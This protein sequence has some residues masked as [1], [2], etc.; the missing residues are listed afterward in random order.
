MEDVTDSAQT[1]SD[2]AVPLA[3]QW[4]QEA[5]AVPPT[6][7]NT[8][9]PPRLDSWPLSAP[10]ETPSGPPTIQE[11]IEGNLYKYSEGR[12]KGW[13]QR[14]FALEGGA[15]RWFE[16]RD[17]RSLFNELD[18]DASGF[19]DRDEVS[20]LFK[21]LGIKMKGKKLDYV[22]SVMDPLQT[23][24]VQFDDFNTWWMEFGGKAVE[25]RSAVGEIWMSAS[26][27]QIDWDEGGDP[28]VFVLR[29]AGAKKKTYRLKADSE[30]EA[31]SWYNKL[32]ETGLDE[33]HV[34]QESVRPL[35]PPSAYAGA[36]R[37]LHGC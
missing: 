29:N 32:S 34:P 20:D 2:H 31:I 6:A 9:M 4:Q 23:N 33:A 5:P 3:V 21:Q 36:N 7:A 16:K 18:A 14:F 8:T 1:V 24:M 37:Y 35:E 26:D 12:G 19:L 22:M 27:I 11:R 13:Q 30:D 17:A 28:C 25:K 10:S 15:L